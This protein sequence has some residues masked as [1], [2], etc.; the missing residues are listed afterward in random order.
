MCVGGYDREGKEIQKSREK[1]IRRQY[2]HT[3]T[4]THI[5][6]ILTLFKSQWLKALDVLAED[7]GSVSSTHMAVHIL[8]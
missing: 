2:T 5:H 7:P 1:V 4:H 8:L 3:H 6:T